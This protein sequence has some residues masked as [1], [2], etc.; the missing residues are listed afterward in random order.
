M[1][2]L[3]SHLEKSLSAKPGGHKNGIKSSVFICG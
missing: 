3:N 2:V 1:G